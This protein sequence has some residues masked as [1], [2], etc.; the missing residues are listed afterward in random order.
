MSGA[1]RPGTL[2]PSTLPR[3][4]EERRYWDLRFSEDR[5]LSIDEWGERLDT[6]I[7]DAVRVRFMSDVPYGAFL[8]GGIDSSLVVG[9]MAELM[10]EPV[11]TFTI[12]FREREFSEV[13]YP[14]EVA[15]L[16]G[17]QHE[18]AIVEADALELLPTL[19]QHYGQPFA[20]SSAIPTYHVSRMASRHVKMVLSG[21]GG[22]ES[23]AGYNSYEYVYAGDARCVICDARTRQQ[24]WFREL[25]RL[26]VPSP[27]PWPAAPLVARPRLRVPG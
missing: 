23:F 11:R 21:D 10:G 2:P 24:R 19:V 14:E 9:Y 12:G 18:T 6:T 7:R 8:S 17:T 15:R 20:D 25:A 27:S 13:E 22:D 26:A 5:S 4:R 3:A 1:C 16:N